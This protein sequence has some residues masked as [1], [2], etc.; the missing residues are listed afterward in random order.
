MGAYWVV[1]GII[2]LWGGA[3]WEGILVPLCRVDGLGV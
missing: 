3:Y 2:R 1:L